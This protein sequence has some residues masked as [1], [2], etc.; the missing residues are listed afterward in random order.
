L[1]ACAKVNGVCGSVCSRDFNSWVKLLGTN[2]V[3]SGVL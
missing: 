2:T 1:A 3:L